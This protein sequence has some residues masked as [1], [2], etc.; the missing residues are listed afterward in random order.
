VPKIQ[1]VTTI[2]ISGAGQLGSRYL[3]GLAKCRIPL[4]IYV[5]DCYQ[6]SLIKSEHLW[7]EVAYAD[8]KHNVSFHISFDELPK[9]LDLVIVAT[10]SDVRPK[11]VA[12]INNLFDVKYWV[13][14]K[15]LAQSQTD[16]NDINKQIKG[17]SGAWVNTPRRMMLWHQQIKQQ[18][19]FGSPLTLTF[20]GGSWG[21]ACNSIHFIDLLVWWTG[22]TL[23][24]ICTDRLQPQWFESKRKG[25]W[26]VEG[27][28]EAKFSGG[29]IARLTADKNQNSTSMVVNEKNLS[30][31]INEVDGIASRSDG[32]EILGRIMYQSEMSTTLVESI[33]EDG[34]CDLPTLDD[35]IALHHVF[36]RSMHEHWVKAGNPNAT[37]VPIT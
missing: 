30:W 12:E 13:L 10:T 33:I 25:F 27:T 22:E 20:V 28:L 3:Q 18:L 34:N 15:V 19:D 29:T 26:E 8:I 11:V 24:S 16:I 1:S 14:E 32:I 9:Q 4:N 36:I 6:E 2:L 21:L 23:E 35:S 7:N 37:F 31:Q 5:Q 17:C